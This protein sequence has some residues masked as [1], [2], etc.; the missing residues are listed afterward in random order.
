MA[1]ID[2][3][4]IIGLDVNRNAAFRESQ[5]LGQS[6]AAIDFEAVSVLWHGC[7]VA[8]AFGAKTFIAMVFREHSFTFA[9]SS[10]FKFTCR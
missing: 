6:D 3:P 2:L 4:T 5:R 8:E 7:F 9:I 1:T 10:A